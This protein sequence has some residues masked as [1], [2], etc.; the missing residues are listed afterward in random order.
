ML[1]GRRRAV[2]RACEVDTSRGLETGDGTEADALLARAIGARTRESFLGPIDRALGLG[3]GALKGLI[4]VSIGFLLIV[5][6]FD[7]VGSF[8]P[9]ARLGDTRIIAKRLAIASR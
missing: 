7:T 3:F 5:L 8:G 1:F 4:L 9:L 2:A 6:L